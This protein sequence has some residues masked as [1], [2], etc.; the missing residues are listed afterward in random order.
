MYVLGQDEPLG[1]PEQPWSPSFGL[2][3]YAPETSAD[4]R[5]GCGFCNRFARPPPH[6]EA[7]TTRRPGR[8]AVLAGCGFGPCCPRAPSGS[9]PSRTS[10]PWSS[11][12]S[13][14]GRCGAWTSWS[15]GSTSWRAAPVPRFTGTALTA[16][17]APP[18]RRAL[19]RP[20]APRRQRLGAAGGDRVRLS[21]RPGRARVVAVVPARV[22]ADAHPREARRVRRADGR[23]EVRVR[24]RRR[25]GG[26]RRA[27]A[28]PLGVERALALVVD[29]VG[30]EEAAFPTAGAGP[31]CPAP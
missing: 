11:C 10:S 28:P 29:R 1:G 5:M 24:R 31:R 21:R 6:A 17:A 22:E 27:L 8:E 20:R 7:A 2:P 19:P 3:K 9:S 13:S 16:S 26:P 30:R 15:H 14:R 23:A 4:A 18:P 12:T 25:R